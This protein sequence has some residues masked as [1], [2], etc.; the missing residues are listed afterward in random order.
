MQLF[1]ADDS[2]RKGIRGGMGN[3]VAFGGIL[4]DE[5]NLRPLNVAIDAICKQYGLP[6]KTELKWSPGKD[7]WIRSNLIK[8]RRQEC[9]REILVASRKHGAQVVVAISDMRR[10]KKQ[11][12]D[13]FLRCVDYALERVNMQVDNAGQYGLIVMDRPGGGKKEEDALLDDVLGTIENGTDFIDFKKICLNALTANSHH[14]RQ[15]QVADLVTGITTAMV[16]GDVGYAAP[17]FCEIIPMFIKNKKDLIGGTGLK[18]YP[19][20]LINL[21]HWLLGENR[22]VRKLGHVDLPTARI[23]Y[24]QDAMAASAA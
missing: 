11:G 24:F 7:N 6:S 21:Y 16:A 13:A 8:E 23:A 3:L 14:V 20:D 12:K 1:F 10:D 17:L 19:D 4:L 15:L 2:A 18:L 9:Y 22:Y 5:K